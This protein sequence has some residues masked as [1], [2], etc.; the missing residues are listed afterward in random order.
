MTA[1]VRPSHSLLD[2]TSP[3]VIRH[4]VA[5]PDVPGPYDCPPFAM[6]VTGRDIRMVDNGLYRR[7]RGSD[8]TPRCS[9]RGRGFAGFP[10]IRRCMPG[11]SPSSP[12]TCRSG[13]VAPALGH[14]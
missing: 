5:P 9:T 7:S 8:R 10:M 12:D 14:R 11:F 6:G 1:S 3:D 13:G 2:A 4:C